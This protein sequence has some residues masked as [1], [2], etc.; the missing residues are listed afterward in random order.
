[1][2]LHCK[3]SLFKSVSELEKKVNKARV[4]TKKAAIKKDAKKSEK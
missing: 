1:M 4:A 3:V 2:G